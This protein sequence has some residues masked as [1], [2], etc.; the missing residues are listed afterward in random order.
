MQ[1]SDTP[2]FER[3]VKS[4]YE[5]KIIKRGRTFFTKSCNIN[6]KLKEFNM[7]LVIIPRLVFK[8]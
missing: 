3:L 7:I 4:N 8:R 6:T 2:P 5:E 1:Q